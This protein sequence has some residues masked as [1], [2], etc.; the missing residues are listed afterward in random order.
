M[1]E[2]QDGTSAWTKDPV[3]TPAIR[4][5]YISLYARKK[6]FKHKDPAA[7]FIGK[8]G[9]FSL[10]FQQDESLW[11]RSDWLQNISYLVA[12]LAV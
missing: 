12:C 6:L 8:V 5:A 7:L 4:R 11:S 10:H 9:D 3:S 2:A 1:P